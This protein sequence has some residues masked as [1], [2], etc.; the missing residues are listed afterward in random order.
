MRLT[1]AEDKGFFSPKSEEGMADADK[2]EEEEADDG[3]EDSIIEPA[4]EGVRRE[5]DG[6]VMRDGRREDGEKNG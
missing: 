1:R 4:G 5:G 6:N 3:V 2:D